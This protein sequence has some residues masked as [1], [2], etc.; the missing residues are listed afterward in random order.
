MILRPGVNLQG[1][2]RLG[3]DQAFPPEKRRETR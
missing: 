3:P 2:I 1:F